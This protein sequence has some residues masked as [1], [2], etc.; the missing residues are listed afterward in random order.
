[1]ANSDFLRDI[2]LDRLL[3]LGG[4]ELS[5]HSADPGDTGVNEVEDV[6]QP[7]V[8]ERTGVGRA[9]NAEPIEFGP[10]PGGRITHFGVWSEG[11][12]LLGMSFPAQDVEMGQAVRWG[13]RDIT[14]RL[15]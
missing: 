7:L 11:R 10:L 6:R 1:M 4:L 8:L 5:L 12:F 9:Q 15:G 13:A 2:W 14:V 3:V